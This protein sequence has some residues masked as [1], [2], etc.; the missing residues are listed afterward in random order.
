M[1]IIHLLSGSGY[2]VP[3]GWKMACAIREA[4]HNP[5]YFSDPGLFDPSRHEKVRN[6]FQSADALLRTFLKLLYAYVYELKAFVYSSPYFS[7]C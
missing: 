5:D 2:V 3:K 4:H 7:F 6:E 1:L